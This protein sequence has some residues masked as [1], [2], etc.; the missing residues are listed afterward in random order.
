L[1]QLWLDSTKK[2]CFLRKFSPFFVAF[3][4]VSFDLVFYDRQMFC[5]GLS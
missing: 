4:K 1:L 3:Y 5:I 2:G